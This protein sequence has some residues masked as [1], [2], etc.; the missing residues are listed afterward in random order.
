MIGLTI[1][2]L[3]I[4]IVFMVSTSRILVGAHTV[5]EVLAGIAVGLIW[6]S[7]CWLGE[8]FLRL[9]YKLDI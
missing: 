2:Y 9:Y 5:T 6:L 3:L 1:L 7:L 8:R 4:I